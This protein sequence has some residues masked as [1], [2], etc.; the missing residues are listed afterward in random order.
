MDLVH[1][2]IQECQELLEVQEIP[3][4][5]F[6]Q[7]GWRRLFHLGL[8]FVLEDQVDLGFLAVQG[9]LDFQGNLLHPLSHCNPARPSDQEGHPALADLEVPA[10]LETLA[11]QEAL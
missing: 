5:L 10:F 3:L 9:S 6:L 4:L 1:L 11:N 7:S 2:E 8:P